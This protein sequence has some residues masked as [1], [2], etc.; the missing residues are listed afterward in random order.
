MAATHTVGAAEAESEC[1]ASS[2][3]PFWRGGRSGHGHSVNRLAR[4]ASGR[5][6]R[7]DSAVTRSLR[8]PARAPRW[9]RPYRAHAGP[10]SLWRFPRNDGRRHEYPRCGRRSAVS[11]AADV[12]VPRLL[13]H[14]RFC[15]RDRQRRDRGQPAQCP[16]PRTVAG[17]AARCCRHRRHRS[18]PPNSR[19]NVRRSTP[20]VRRR[21]SPGRWW[22]SESW[23]SAVFCQRGPAA[24]GAPCTCTSRSGPMRRSRQQPLPHSRLRWQSD[25]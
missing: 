8:R 2:A 19:D 4:R 13:Q 9:R 18:L 5:K 15:R 20:R 11:K 24:T 3:L 23:L 21:G 16:S 1:R 12:D 6:E 22:R 25:A 17:G 10:G 14:R 7:G